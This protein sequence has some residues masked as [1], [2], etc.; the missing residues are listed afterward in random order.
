MHVVQAHRALRNTKARHAAI[1]FQ[2]KDLQNRFVAVILTMEGGIAV[3]EDLNSWVATAASWITVL[4]AAWAAIKWLAPKM[5][6][7]LKMWHS[8]KR[9]R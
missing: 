9:K 5:R 8:C 7:S 2:K 4:G 6:E 3:I 1:A